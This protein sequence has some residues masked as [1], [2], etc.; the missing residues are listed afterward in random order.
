VPK[1]ASKRLVIDAS[2]ARAAGT[3]EHPVSAACRAALET[4]LQ[5]CRRVV[6]TAEISEEWR[7]HRS[8]FF[9]AWL[10]SMTARKKV[11][12][13]VPA[14]ADEL[15]ERIDRLDVS[16][17]VRGAMTKDV[18]LLVAALAADLIVISA[19]ETARG[20]F[21]GLAR[22]AAALRRIVWVNP[23]KVEDEAVEWL[24]RGAIAETR[25]ELGFAE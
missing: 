25:R 1:V 6:A 13:T 4:I 15:Q 18:R 10:A 17:N 2:V 11:A 16:D 24:K 3:T 19:D 21:K 22:D 23:L 9:A 20:H 5:V 12:R 14:E 7:A 8:R